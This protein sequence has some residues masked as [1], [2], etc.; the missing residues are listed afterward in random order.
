[1][2]FNVGDRVR[3]TMN[4]RS[5]NRE[6]TVQNERDRDHYLVLMDP[7]FDGHTRENRCWF[8]RESHLELIDTN[9]HIP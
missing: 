5:E 7:P 3:S 4:D 8:I 6:G 2:P 9:E 1:M